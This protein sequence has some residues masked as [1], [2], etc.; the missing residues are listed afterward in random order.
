M[1]FYSKN[2]EGY[3]PLD[4]NDG[5]VIHHREQMTASSFTVTLILRSC[6][7]GVGKGD[8]HQCEKLGLT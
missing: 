3:S 7:D 8:A 6:V 5:H 4:V 2:V 1:R